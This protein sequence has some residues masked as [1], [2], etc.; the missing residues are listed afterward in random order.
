MSEGVGAGPAGGTG[1]GESGDARTAAA[2]ARVQLDDAEAAEVKASAAFDEAKIKAAKLAAK[3]GALKGAESPQP[4]VAMGP[5]SST[6]LLEGELGFVRKMVE[7]KEA[8]LK[9]H[10]AQLEVQLAKGGTGKGKG[11][12]ARADAEPYATA[13]GDA[14]ED[15]LKENLQ[16]LVTD[17]RASTAEAKDTLNQLEVLQ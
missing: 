13:D 7:G 2:K 11:S 14:K 8:R 5:S 6:L 12:D 10:A 15:K 9:A 1:G 17:S 3:L 16:I 4:D